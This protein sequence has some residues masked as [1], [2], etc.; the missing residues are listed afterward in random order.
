[1]FGCTAFDYTPSLSNLTPRAL[2]GVFFA[3]SR[4]QKGYR[5]Y[6]SNTLRYITSADV[7]FHED[8]PYFSL[9]TTPLRAPISPP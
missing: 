2:K 9:S 7:T 3:Y 1:M 6:F 8:V 5:V 4:T